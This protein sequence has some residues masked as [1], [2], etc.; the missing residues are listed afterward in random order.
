MIEDNPH[1][2]RTKEGFL[3]IM[4]RLQ[5]WERHRIYTEEIEEQQ[6]E[7]AETLEM[8]IG[9]LETRIFLATFQKEG[10][11]LEGP[12]HEQMEPFLQ[13]IKAIDVSD[14]FERLGELDAYL[15]QI[16]M[17]TEVVIEQLA[18]Q[19]DLENI[20]GFHEL[21]YDWERLLPDKRY[22][23]GISRDLVDPRDIG[24]LSLEFSHVSFSKDVVDEFKN[25][26]ELGRRY[27]I[28]LHKGY[29][30]HRRSS[31]VRKD[32][33]G[34]PKSMRDIKVIRRGGKVRLV[35]KVVEDEQGGTLYLFDVYKKDATYQGHIWTP[36]INAFDPPIDPYEA[37]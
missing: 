13:Q 25:N 20:Y 7:Q 27:L 11:D 23:L 17:A 28:A 8:R 34:V 21:N 26:P 18:A 33:K 14:W 9:M 22:D 3:L 15:T 36:I 16:E 31:G 35:G 19:T 32:F 24:L 1:A 4:F 12:M 30:S 2:L 5:A 6:L 29:V 10:F 37:Q